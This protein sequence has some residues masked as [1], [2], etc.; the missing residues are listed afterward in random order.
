MNFTLKEFFYNLY[1][2]SLLSMLLSV[3]ALLLIYYFIFIG[4]I[5]HLV[6]DVFIINTL[7]IITPLIVIVALTIVHLRIAKHC[8]K[9]SQEP[10]LGNKLDLYFSQA[11]QKTNSIIFASLILSTGFAL[12]SNET[13]SIYF[14]VLILWNLLQWPFPKK[15]CNNL[16]LK[17]DER[18]MVMTK[19]EAFKI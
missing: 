3:V 5:P 12:T 17:G 14:A 8:K 11:T 2:R 4:I 10:N 15:V 13:F 19:G 16:K 7:L 1:N 6:E 9:I 18:K